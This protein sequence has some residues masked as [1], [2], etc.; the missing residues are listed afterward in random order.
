[1]K[2][3]NWNDDG[4]LTSWIIIAIVGGLALATIIVIWKKLMKKK[5]FTPYGI[6]ETYEVET[7]RHVGRDYG[8]RENANMGW[9][10]NFKRYRRKKKNRN[11]DQYAVCHTYT[12]WE[13]HVK[14]VI[15]HNI[16]NTNDLI[17]WLY[18]K[19]DWAMRS[20]EVEK[21]I[22]VPV[23]VALLSLIIRDPEKYSFAA[24][25]MLFVFLAGII[26]WVSIDCLFKDFVEVSFYND[27]ISV[28]EKEL[29]N[30]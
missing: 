19:R 26:I 7:Y 2:F 20:L 9:I 14:T 18:Q 30:K 15:N 29:L 5:Y 28:V 4:I 6:D 8:N 1:M 10:L 27:F 12:Q 25:L 22:L 24:V 11:Q 17:H 13:N 23:Y 3:Y 16:I 21:L